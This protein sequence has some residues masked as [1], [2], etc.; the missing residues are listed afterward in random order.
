MRGPGLMCGTR[1]VW[2]EDAR[3]TAQVVTP[4]H[5]KYCSLVTLSGAAYAPF[6]AGIPCMT[7]PQYGG[8]TM[9]EA[10][11]LV[12][13]ITTIQNSENREHDQPVN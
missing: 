9:L 4:S 5:A 8:F 10:Q 12:V 11:A 3:R 6:A 2:L 1:R 7:N 13:S